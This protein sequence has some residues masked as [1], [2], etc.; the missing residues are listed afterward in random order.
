MRTTID[1]PDLIYRE[2]KSE[3]AFEGTSVKK[4][5]LR[6]VEARPRREAKAPSTGKFKAPAVKSKNPGSLKLG[7]EG[8]YEYIPFP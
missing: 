6:S 7:P 1:I 5:I 3:A 2:L 8:V 4:L